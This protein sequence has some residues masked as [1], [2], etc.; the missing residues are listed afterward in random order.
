MFL[1]ERRWS[2]GRAALHSEGLSP[3]WASD[4]AWKVKSEKRCA[5]E[6]GRSSGGW[7][8]ALECRMNVGSGKDT[9]SHYSL[10]K[11]PE[12]SAPVLLLCE[13]D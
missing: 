3:L 6:A 13:M 8:K 7:A 11:S 12:L 9:P 2:A 4:E 5:Q 1:G 10:S